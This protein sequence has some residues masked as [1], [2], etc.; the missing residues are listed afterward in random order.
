MKKTISFKTAIMV[1]LLTLT[2][3][4][5]TACGGKT[6]NLKNIT[7]I[8]LADGSNGNS[9]DIIEQD[10]IQALIQQFNDNV[11]KKSESS[12]NHSGWSYRLRFF[13]DDKVKT[14]VV[15]MG[16][17][18]IDFE[19]SFYDIK[20]GT[21]DVN[22]YKELFSEAAMQNA[23]V[24]APL[25]YVSLITHD[26]PVQRV[27]AIQLTTSWMFIDENGNGSGYEADSAHPLQI[28][29]SD[30]NE[31]TLRLDSANGEIE[32]QFSDNHPPQSVSVQRW[33]AEYA[34]GTQDI[35]DVLD[36]SEPVEI[37][38]NIIRAS[39]DGRDYVY[40]VYA[41][42]AEGSSYYTFRMESTKQ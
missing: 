3:L 35:A 5:L 19:G 27:Q 14:E 40:E 10:Q 41:T 31:A 34:A 22:Y 25:L 9:V 24:K 6:F 18:R 21:L 12:K 23:P 2:A 37:N 20:S 28:Q 8:E 42:W 17:G 38:G 39:D 16:S 30:F 11:F 36:K 7:K 13:Q 4:T 15:V 1:C 33:N 29:P 26:S 32:I